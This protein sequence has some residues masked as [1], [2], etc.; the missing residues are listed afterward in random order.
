MVQ[1]LIR[2]SGPSNRLEQCRQDLRQLVSLVW[3]ACHRLQIRIGIPKTMESIGLKNC[4]NL[5]RFQPGC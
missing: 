1:G 4:I 3:I 5:G 2:I